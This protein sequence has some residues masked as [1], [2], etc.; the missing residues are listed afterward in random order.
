MRMS[1]LVLRRMALLSL[2]VFAL[3][4]ALVAWQSQD[5]VQREVGSAHA[6]A[7]VL[8]MV[9]DLPLQ[10]PA[11]RAS[12]LRA[13]DAVVE[14]GQL[15]HLRIRIL[16]Q[17]GRDLL[18]PAPAQRVSRLQSWLFAT[19]TR[20]RPEQ[21]HAPVSWVLPL[22]DGGRYLVTLTVDPS[23]EQREAMQGIVD[24]LSVLA[25][26]G[27]LMLAAAWWSLRQALSPLQGI[28]GAID[29][30]RRHD[31]SR[32]APAG[33]THEMN[34]IS[35][36]LN[37]LARS[38]EDAQQARTAL[39]MKL[40]TLQEDERAHLA[41]EL[42]DEFGQMLTAMQRIGKRAPLYCTGVGKLFLLEWEPDLVA[43]YLAGANP[44]R[45]TAN[46]ITTAEAL[47]HELASVR[48]AGV[49]YD[50]EECEIGAKCIAAPIR[51][52][53]GKI[54]AAISITGPLVR[55]TPESQAGLV[56]VLLQPDS[57]LPLDFRP[58]LTLRLEPL[59]G[60]NLPK[61]ALALV[62]GEPTF[63][64]VKNGKAEAVKAQI[65]RD[66]NGQ[67]V[68]S[69]QLTPADSIAASKVDM[70]HDAIQVQVQP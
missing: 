56:R 29:G 21:R 40:L 8:D 12:T 58:N 47:Q 65:I 60:W 9:W 68:V 30:Y 62:E 11:R 24:L 61:T 27:L 4:A 70:L 41:R 33:N 49:A 59:T 15:R 57:L 3:G 45:F 32:R 14:A 37:H 36:A 34:A 18:A 2:L 26:S 43:R 1:R 6:I 19:L 67:V 35:G 44:E 66:L 10:D 55:I 7:R 63:Y 69:N 46:T 51:D 22:A 42:H 54:V 17:G 50:N 25:L 13:I 5:D 52:Y 16:D 53:T 48:Q 39:S 20:V 38:L 64:L 28:L 31:F 23:S